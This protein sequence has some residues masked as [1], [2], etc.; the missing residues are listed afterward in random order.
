MPSGADAHTARDDLYRQP[1]ESLMTRGS[2]DGVP[3]G[4]PI[5]MSRLT[6]DE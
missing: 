4:K 5:P 3:S 6:A 1:V 2:A